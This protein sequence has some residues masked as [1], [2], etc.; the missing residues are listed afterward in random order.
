VAGCGGSENGDVKSQ[1][2]DG[3]PRDAAKIVVSLTFD[4]AEATQVVAGDLLRK[5]HLVGTFFINS[6]FLGKPE[7][8]TKAQVHALAA[9]GN[10]IGGHTLTHPHLPKLSKAAQRRQV[11]DDRRALTAMGYKRAS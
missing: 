9:A 6:G 7:R 3:K 4:D 11:C 5:Y 10:E 2:G 1:S 8:L